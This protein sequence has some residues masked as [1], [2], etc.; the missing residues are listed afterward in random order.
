MHCKYFYEWYLWTFPLLPCCK[1]AL[2]T[3]VVLIRRELRD[4]AI[5]SSGL[6][7][8]TQLLPNDKET[9]A[10]GTPTMCCQETFRFTLE[11]CVRT[12]LV[13]VTQKAVSNW[14]NRTTPVYLEVPCGGRPD[15]HI[16]L[17]PSPEC[18][19][20]H[21]FTLLWS[22]VISAMATYFGGMVQW[23]HCCLKMHICQR[24]VLN[25]HTSTIQSAF[26]PWTSIVGLTLGRTLQGCEL[27][28]FKFAFPWHIPQQSL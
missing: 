24:N 8:E 16:P 4:R 7:L 5:W 14:R 23:S 17:L 28:M 15:L 18:V 3:G 13:A 21:L 26:S 27:T 9:L 22:V 20:F 19:V 1:H 12:D 11:K 2:L 10:L 6:P 25:G